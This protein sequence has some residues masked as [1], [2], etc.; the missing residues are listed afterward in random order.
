MKVAFLDDHK[1]FTEILADFV[2]QKFPD[3]DVSNFDKASDFL[4]E[5]NGK[6]Y[7]ICVVDLEMPEM[8]GV[9]VIR[10]LQEINPEQK[11]IV[12]SMYYNVQ[13]AS[14][15]LKLNVK[16]FLPKNIDIQDFE[17]ALLAVQKGEIYY[18]EELLKRMAEEVDRKVLLT[19]RELEIINLSAAGNTSKMIAAT[20]FVSEETVRTHIKNIMAKTGCANFK[21]VIAN[22]Q[23]EGW[24][25]LT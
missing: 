23:R 15:L 18:K 8:S 24:E 20:I 9:E 7:D 13:I 22:Y 11:I 25:V 2:R 12:L 14:E 3:S 17:V 6:V 21:E 16:S 1:L 10:K 19:R 5:A 4:K